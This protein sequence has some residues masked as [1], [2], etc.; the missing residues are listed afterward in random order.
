MIRLACLLA[1]GLLVG[2]TGAPRRAAPPAERAAS[3]PATGSESGGG[4]YAPHIRDGAP[5]ELPD[6]D[7]IPEPVPR[8]EPPARYG[9]RSPYTVLGKS[10]RVMASA[11][12]YRER[13]IASWY[14]TK[15]H[16]RPTSSFEPYDLARFTAAH[17]TLPLP[18]YARV[19]N[20]EN[21]R[22]VVVRVNDRGPFHGDRL[23]DLSYAAA[24]KLGV[25]RKGTALVEV[26]ALDPVDPE[27]AP[28]PAV[29][30][31]Q[32]SVHAWVQV[33]SFSERG[34][35]E[36]LARRL[37]RSLDT[38]VRVLDA[39]VGDRRFWRVRIGPYAQA[40]EAVD[41]AERVRAAGFGEPTLVTE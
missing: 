37:R 14:G 34:N 8:A 6:V 5:T 15:F 28:P 23:I 9:N 33:G 2:C 41:S 31:G 29:A 30:V 27:P 16:G 19:T 40:A 21:G 32:G 17:K 25:D 1:L 11:K 4:L 39:A 38:E 10:Y 13:G 18:T 12:G 3:A 26:Q 7:S 35:A 20:L 36:D 24:V 22:S